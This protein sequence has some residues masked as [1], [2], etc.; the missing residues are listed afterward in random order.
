MLDQALRDRLIAKLQHF[1]DSLQQR[2]LEKETLSI[3]ITDKSIRSEILREILIYEEIIEE[4]YSDFK[5]IL[6][7]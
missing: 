4:Y 3:F 2:K 5:D 1:A 7:R 6:T